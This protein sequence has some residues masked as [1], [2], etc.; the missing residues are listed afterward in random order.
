M[1]P[2][3]Y[4][5]VYI[6]EA[7]SGVRTITAVSTS[8]AAFLGRTTRGKLNKAERLLS[9]ADFDRKFG[10]PHPRSDLAYNV[11]QF[12]D[13]G[14]TDCY[15][16]RL[17]DNAVEAD[18]QLTDLDGNNMLLASAA[19]EG[20]WGNSVRIEINYNT[21]NPDESFNMI[22]IQEEGGDEIARETHT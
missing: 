12:F 3:S 8:I 15:V 22:I 17:A 11:R 5:G 1:Q 14:G 21:V 4:P 13:N 16:V 10:A 6:N 18:L 7:S 20:A 2:L 9:P 19:T